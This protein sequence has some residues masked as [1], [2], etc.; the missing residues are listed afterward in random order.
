MSWI[1]GDNCNKFFEL[2]SKSGVYQV[3][4]TTPKTS[5]GIITLTVVEMQRLPDI[6]K[7]DSQEKNS[8]LKC[9][10]YNGTRKVCLYFKT[11]TDKLNIIVYRYRKNI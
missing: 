10:I 2:K 11:D 3:A 6:E 5:L 9:T 4:H 8:C 1:I 7:T